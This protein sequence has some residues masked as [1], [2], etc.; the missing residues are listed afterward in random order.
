VTTCTF[1]NYLPKFFNSYFLYHVLIQDE[2]KFKSCFCMCFNDLQ[3]EQVLNK[4]EEGEPESSSNNNS[5]EALKTEEQEVEDD[6]QEESVVE[7]EAD[8]DDDMLSGGDLNAEDVAEP[9]SAENQENLRNLT[10]KE[11]KDLGD[12]LGEDWKKV[13]NKLGF[14]PDEVGLHWHNF[15]IYL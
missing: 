6:D 7:G 2:T 3:N 13:A 15:I 11:Q 1:E 14:T 8:E 10:E 5:N 4:N 12:S 9:G